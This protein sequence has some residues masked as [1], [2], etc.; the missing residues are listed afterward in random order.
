M[1]KKLN[2]VIKVKEIGKAE[3]ILIITAAVITK[4]FLSMPTLLVEQSGN[5]VWLVI[6]LKTLLSLAI[7]LML[8]SIYK[9]FFEKDIFDLLEIAFNKAGRIIGGVFIFTVLISMA[10]A[11]EKNMIREIKMTA[12]SSGRVEFIALFFLVPMT[13]CAFLGIE[14][15]GRANVIISIV[16]FFA[17]AIIVIMLWRLCDIKNLYP[18]LGKGIRQVLST[19]AVN[20]NIF[21]EVGIIFLLVPFLRDFKA[22]QSIGKNAILLSGMLTAIWS[23]SYCLVIPYPITAKIAQPIYELTRLIKSGVFWQ[24]LDPL[25]IFIS[26]LSVQIY[27]S[28]VLFFSA[29][30]LKRTF[31]LNSL[32]PIVPILAFSVYLFSILPMSDRHLSI[33]FEVFFRYGAIFYPIFPFIVLLFARRKIK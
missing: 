20:T 27:L 32:R 12:L 5:A 22:F 13:V 2:E 9:N 21:A 26:G 6:I 24:R 23:L 11:V 16:S 30:T 29:Y 33:F 4:F 19:T 14:S 28:G 18:I 25:V 17:T 1:E 8:S 31:K 7:F 3:G 15:I 10:T